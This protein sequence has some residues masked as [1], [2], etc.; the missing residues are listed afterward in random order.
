MAAEVLIIG[1]G[2]EYRGDDG[3]GLALVRTLQA[4]PPPGTRIVER[5]G[6]GA[7]LLDTW[8][9]ASIVIVLDAVVAGRAPGALLRLDVRREPLPGHYFAHSSHAFGIAQTVELARALGEL[10]DELIIYGVQGADFALGTALSAPVAAAMDVALQLIR[11]DVARLREQ[12][13]PRDQ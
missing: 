4:A 9:G 2:N 13:F 3:V 8:R 6:E 1:V 7:G 12:E 11:Q 10:P 5:S